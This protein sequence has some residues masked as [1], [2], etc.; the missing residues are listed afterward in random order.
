M[1]GFLPCENVNYRTLLI[2]V[3]FWSDRLLADHGRVTGGS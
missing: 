3:S 1:I 2:K